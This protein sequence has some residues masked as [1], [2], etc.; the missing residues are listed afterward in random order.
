MDAKALFQ[1]GVVAIRD[2]KDAAKGRELLM[3][4]L[5][6]E[7][8]NEMAWLWLS[9]TMAEPQKKIQCLERA[10]KLNPTNEQTK[11]LISKL[12]ADTPSSS[13]GTKAAAPTPAPVHRLTP[14]PHIKT[15]LPEKTDTS[16]WSSLRISTSEMNAVSGSSLKPQVTAEMEDMGLT[17]DLGAVL[18]ATSEMNAVTKRATSETAVA[19][20]QATSSTTLNDSQTTHEEPE[21]LPEIKAA[22][23]KKS[24]TAAENTQ[25]KNYLSQA[26]SLLNKNKIEEAIEQ[27]VR[28]LDI[29]VDNETALGNAVR[30]LSR[31]KYIDDARELV[32]N[33]LKSGTR[34][35]SIYLTAID[36][37]K[38]QGHDGEADD[39]RL[40]LVQLPEAGEKTVMMVVEYFVE[41]QPQKALQ[42][43]DL[44]IPSYPKSQKLTFQRAQL[45]ENMGLR[46]EAATYYEEAAQLGTRSKEGQLADKKLTE[47]MPHMTD[48]ER[49]SVGLAIREALGVGF[50]YLLMGFQDAGLNLMQLG[51]SRIGGIVMSIVGGYLLVTAT[52]SAQQ[53]PLASWLG[54]SIPVK[55]EP[56]PESKPE[57]ED[58]VK[59]IMGE[60]EEEVTQL[61]VIPTAI[62][63]VIG[64]VGVILLV[65][66]FV[67]VFSA[68]IA[69]LR[70]GSPKPFYVP[71]IDEMLKGE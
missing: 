57:K 53:K 40:K 70:N 45:A 5:K 44:A 62:R 9:R 54:G 68:A 36:I 22:P 43:L 71:T 18:T 49:A 47:F 6:I 46:K 3:Q 52:S 7:P 2:Q 33:A 48:K 15:P 14:L 31:L 58:V 12:A 1:E 69:L 41:N 10:L 28:V 8:K 20:G 34:H 17:P 21:V 24:L 63:V 61:P 56:E 30:Y 4:S 42:A 25:I 29:E 60:P 51:A 50:L 66:A 39:L 19:N 64:I 59:A 13:N 16:N 35:P 37:A 27:W 11:A 55:K 26:Q 32:W 38:Y 67:L 65:S 23:N